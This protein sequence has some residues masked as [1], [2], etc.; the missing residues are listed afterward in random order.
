MRMEEDQIAKRALVLWLE[1]HG[2]TVVQQE[3]RAPDPQYIDVWHVPAPDAA[4][5]SA[6]PWLALPL[7][8]AAEACLF[9]PYSSTLKPQHV[10][11]NQRKQL[12]FH[13]QLCKEAQKKERPQPPLPL[14]WLIS[15]GRPERV[16]DEYDF[17]PLP[18]W[19]PGFYQFHRGSRI[20]LLVLTELPPGVP[21]LLLRLLGAGRPRR[22]ALSEL[23]ALGDSD[24]ARQ[25]RRLVVELRDR[26]AHDKQ[27]VAE[28]REDFMTAAKAQFL[29]WEQELINRY[30]E[31]GIEQ[32]IEQGVEQGRLRELR[33]GTRLLCQA[34]AIELT[35][36]RAANID[37][38]DADALS[39]LQDQLLASRAW[40]A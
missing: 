7:R 12:V 13:H 17:A 23:D 3:V 19:P 29:K 31:Q 5:A 16:F 10:R 20:A 9:E 18:T 21:T 40:P 26:V 27:I 39:A 33:R 25:L 32:G 15:P 36:A 37:S 35:E 34:F 38:L 1:D 22:Q 14:L 8:M 30:K 4:D 11:D 2:T 6:P 24:E 28:E